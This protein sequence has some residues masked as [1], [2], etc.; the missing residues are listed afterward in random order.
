MEDRVSWRIRGELDREVEAPVSVTRQGPC[1]GGGSASRDRE[2]EAEV[3]WDRVEA[4][5]AIR[6]VN[7]EGV[8]DELQTVKWGQ[9]NG[10]R[11]ATSIAITDS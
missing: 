4:S 1:G 10:Q 11:R 9:S 6:T 5:G 8:G 7:L 2:M 3:A